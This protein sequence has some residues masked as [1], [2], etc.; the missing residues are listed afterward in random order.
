MPPLDHLLALGFTKDQRFKSTRSVFRDRAPDRDR[1]T[2][3]EWLL[4][5]LRSVADGAARLVRP[6]TQD[7]SQNEPGLS[8][9]IEISPA[10]SLDPATLE[11]KRDRIEVL[12]VVPNG[13]SEII[14]VYVPPGKLRAFEDRIREYLAIDVPS[15]KKDGRPR[16]KHANLINAIATFQQAVFD[17]LWTDERDPPERDEATVFQVWLRLAGKAPRA[18]WSEFSEAAIQLG[19]QIEPGYLTFPGRLVVAA[20]STRAALEEAIGLVDLVA[21]IRGTSPSAQFFLSELRPF[22]QVEWVRDL[23]TR[24]TTLQVGENPPFITLLDTGVNRGHPLIAPLLAEGDLHAVVDTWGTG[25]DQRHGSEMAGISLHGDLRGPLSSKEEHG[26]PHR[27]ESVKILPPT[28]ANPPHLYG[29]TAEEAARRVEEANP[30]RTRT[31]AMTTTALGNTSGWPSEWSATIDRL[32][33]GHRGASTN[34]L[35]LP[36]DDLVAGTG[37]PR[38]FVLSAGNIEWTDWVNYPDN[39]S[40]QTIEDPGQAWNALTVGAYTELVEI[41]EGKWPNLRAIATRGA[42]SPCSRTSVAWSRSWPHKPDVVAEGGNG[43]YDDNAQRQVVVGPEDLRILTTTSKPIRSLL[44]ESGDTSGAA[45]EVARIC[46]HLQARYP[47]YWAETVRALVVSGAGYTRA[48]G[49][50]AATTQLAREALVGRFGYGRVSMDASLNS[51]NKRPTVVLQE[52]I[53]PYVR[54]GGDNKLGQVNFHSLPWPAAEL[55]G[56]GE[57]RVT[58]KVTLSY[59]IHPNPSRRGWQSKFRYQSHGLRFAVRGATETALRFQ[60]R[61]NKLKRDEVPEDEREAAMPDPDSDGWFLRSNIRARGSL[62][63]DSWSGTAAQLANKSEIA[64]YPVG[65]WWKDVGTRG[66][67]DRQ[68]RYALVVSLE[69]HSDA[70]VDIYTPI[71]NQIAIPIEAR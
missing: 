33:F 51:A 66:D 40:L 46:A 11:W 69:V 62:H 25:D 44:G 21:E 54:E 8:V 31:F 60:Q 65:G 20:H 56:L 14:T 10:G 32:A 50:E 28:G 3:G 2:H 67:E 70:E 23:V 22:E 12:N 13:A 1:H 5:Q 17:Q 7:G 58:L 55:E 37:T 48:M 9:A 19:I 43:C 68:V 27:L 4:A 42:L 36:E 47:Q 53:K 64:V 59:F 57:T 6:N 45:A 24:M 71:A 26:V 38:L 63:S 41:D 16:P 52:L 34:S 35:D 15:R 29:W 18:L 61:I 30:G 39:N 49:G